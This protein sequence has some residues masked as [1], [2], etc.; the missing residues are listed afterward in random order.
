MIVYIVREAFSTGMWKHEHFVM[1]RIKLTS[2]VFMH[3]N[4][5]L[6]VCL[7]RILS[8]WFFTV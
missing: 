8:T 2:F 4:M 6:C 3:W 7:H 5:Y 1:S